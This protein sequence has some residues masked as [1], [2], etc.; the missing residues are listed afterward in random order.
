MRLLTG[1]GRPLPAGA[2]ATGS[3]CMA[4][5]GDGGDCLRCQ[6]TGCDPDPQAPAGVVIAP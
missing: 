6:G 2:P 4:C 1:P 3:P 5:L